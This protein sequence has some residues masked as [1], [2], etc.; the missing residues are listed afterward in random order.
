LSLSVPIRLYPLLRKD[1]MT[2]FT[3]AHGL[4]ED[5]IFMLT[6]DF[7]GI[8]ETIIGCAFR[9]AN[10]LG[11]GFME[12]V[13]ENALAFELKNAGLTASQQHPIQVIYEDQVVGDYIADLLV[14]SRVIVE[15]KAVKGIETVHFA[16]CMNYLKATQL[17]VCLL[18]NF[19]GP[20]LEFKRIVMDL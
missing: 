20:K 14:D 10:T 2:V 1:L 4:V 5:D 13:Y 18:I 15:L 17:K 11:S 7:Y 3:A 19:G 6:T 16:Q 9:V 12:K 8:T